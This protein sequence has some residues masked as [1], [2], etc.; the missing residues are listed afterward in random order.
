ML[1]LTVPT[2]FTQSNEGVSLRGTQPKAGYEKTFPLRRGGWLTVV[3]SP[4]ELEFQE[5]QACTS[6]NVTDV[7]QRFPLCHP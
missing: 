3:T 5:V 1:K 4:I 7:S 2:F 6:G